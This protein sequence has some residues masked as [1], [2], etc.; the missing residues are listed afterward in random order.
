MLPPKTCHTCDPKCP[1]IQCDTDPDCAEKPSLKPCPVLPRTV[2]V[3]IL[4]ATIIANVCEGCENRRTSPAAT[5]ARREQ[6]LADYAAETNERQR[7]VIAA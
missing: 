1:G 7:D 4:D 5:L 6:Y 2:N 3:S